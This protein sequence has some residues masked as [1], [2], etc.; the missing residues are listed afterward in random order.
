M[1]DDERIDIKAQAAYEAY[2]R[3]FGGIK[4]TPWWSLHEDHR[5]R[6]HA[7]VK[8]IRNQKRSTTPCPTSPTTSEGP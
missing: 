7:V 8:A 6:W 5:R 4:P 2:W 1:T 3:G